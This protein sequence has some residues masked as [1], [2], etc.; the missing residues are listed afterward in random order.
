MKM[1]LTVEAEY[2]TGSEEETEHAYGTVD[3]EACAQIDVDQMSG[4]PFLL[5]QTLAA[6][7]SEGSSLTVRVNPVTA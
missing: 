6:F 2:D 3:P 5:L 1:Q 7:I 4:S